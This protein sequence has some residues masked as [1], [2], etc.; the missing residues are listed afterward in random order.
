MLLP[1]NFSCSYFICVGT[2][3]GWRFACVPQQSKL[4]I[5]AWRGAWVSLAQVLVAWG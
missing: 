1:Y 5:A 2:G 4:A 3:Q